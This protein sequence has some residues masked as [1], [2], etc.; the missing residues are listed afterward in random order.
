MAS[1]IPIC[2]LVIGLCFLLVPM[3]SDALAGF[4]LGAAL[5][6]AGMGLFNLGAEMAMTP[7]GEAVGSVLTRSRKMSIVLAGGFLVGLLV[8]LAEPDLTVLAGQVPGIPNLVLILAVALGVDREQVDPEKHRRSIIQRVLERGSWED[9]KAVKAEYTLPSIVE[10]AQNMRSL[11][12]TALAFVSCVG[13]VPKESF[14]CCSSK[15]SNLPPWP[16]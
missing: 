8:T 12:P 6:I 14:R 1:V 3:P 9:W 11:E 10:E 15:P 4:G 2:A 16:C 5:L 13:H 7:I